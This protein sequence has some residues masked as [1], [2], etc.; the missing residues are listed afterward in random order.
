MNRFRHLPTSTRPLVRN[1]AHVF[2]MRNA[3]HVFAPDAVCS[4]IAGNHST[5]LRYAVA[6]ANGCARGS[7]DLV[8]IESDKISFEPDLR[9]AFAAKYSFAVL[10]CPYRRLI[11]AFRDLI[12]PAQRPSWTLYNHAGRKFHPHEINFSQ[13]VTLVRKQSD[14]QR[15]ERWRRQT[16]FLLYESY[17]D[18]FAAEKFEVLA[19]VLSEKIGLELEPE[20]IE[21]PSIELEEQADAA[22][23]PALKLLAMRRKG[24]ELSDTS[25]FTDAIIRQIANAWRDDIAL[26]RDAGFGELMLFDS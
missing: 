5:S 20:A 2:A 3:M 8:W 18:F 14:A 4:V 12:I 1:P 10:A 11:H 24:I 6:R 26:Y 19:A 9:S 13:F 16:D 22:S 17:D 7:E 21:A 25:F 23:I 15:D